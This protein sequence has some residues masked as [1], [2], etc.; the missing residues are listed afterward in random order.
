MD[1]IVDLGM[2]VLPVAV[3]AGF[4]ALDRRAGGRGN[5]VLAAVVGWMCAVSG[6]AVSGMLTRFD[7]R[8][9]PFML[10]LVAMLAVVTATVLSPVGRRFS[11]LPLWLLVGSQVFRLPLEL[12]MHRAADI[13]LM[14]V[15]MSF[16]G[17]N[18]DILTGLLAVPV[19]WASTR[20]RWGEIAAWAWNLLGTVLLVNVV[21]VAVLS[22]PI[23]HRWGTA[24]SEL[25]TWVGYWPY[26]WL[27]TVLVANAAFTHAI[28][29]RRLLT[30]RRD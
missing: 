30:R 24:P 5:Q 12:V 3:A 10:L 14:P 11:T 4:I 13:G 20:A 16:S 29:W 15:Q 27:P 1:P 7:V 26:V 17:R 28:L 2:I 6:V 22:T 23:F 18:F 9:P 25:N 21:A 19:A 8:P